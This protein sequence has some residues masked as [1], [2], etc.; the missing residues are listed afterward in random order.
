MRS[1]DFCLSFALILCLQVSA[2]QQIQDPLAGTWSSPKKT[3]DSSADC[4]VPDS[5]EI[6]KSGSDYK[7][8]YSY[9][10]WTNLNC[11][12]MF[13]FSSER[14]VDIAKKTNSDA[15]GI[16]VSIF[17]AFPIEG[18]RARVLSSS[19]LEIY[20]PGNSTVAEASLCDFTMS[21]FVPAST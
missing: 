14:N 21:T 20:N 7:G 15:Y 8:T 9:S 10:K 11:V 17:D 1:F 12:A 13:L 3:I 19:Q 6:V 16:S 2:Q 5:I 18:Y 4:C